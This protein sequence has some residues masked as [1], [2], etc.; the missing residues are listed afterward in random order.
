MPAGLS[1]KQ[2]LLFLI[3]SVI[4]LTCLLG[5]LV[6]RSM[7]QQMMTDRQELIRGQVENALSLVASYEERAPPARCRRRKLSARRC[8]R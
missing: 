4:A 6:L 5:G 1:L 8:W 2:R 7:H 3:C